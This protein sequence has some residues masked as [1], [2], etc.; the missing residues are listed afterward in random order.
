MRP[1]SVAFVPCVVTPAGPGVAPAGLGGASAAGAGVVAGSAADPAMSGMAPSFATG[2]LAWSALALS[3]FAS[4]FSSAALCWYFSEASDSAR[5]PG[6]VL[7]WV[8]AGSGTCSCVALMM[9][10]AGCACCRTP[11]TCQFAAKLP[12]SICVPPESVGSR[13][14][15]TIK[16]TGQPDCPIQLSESCHLDLEC[17]PS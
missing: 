16:S 12:L 6:S 8:E 1:S 3:A 7:D 10:A 15:V 11:Q 9:S 2:V 4:G 13:V 5:A 14:S 17:S